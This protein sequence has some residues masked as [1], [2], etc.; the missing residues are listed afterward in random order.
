MN[1]TPFIVAVN[2]SGLPHPIPTQPATGDELLTDMSPQEIAT[3]FWMLQSL[4][5]SYSY[6]VNGLGTYANGYTITCGAQPVERLANYPVFAYESL[7][8]T[9]SMGTFFQLN[10]AQV[11]QGTSTYALN[12][13]FQEGTYPNGEIL[14][15]VN[16]PAGHTVLDTS[17]LVL[18][19][20]TIPLYLSTSYTGLTGSI[21][22][23][24]IGE[25]YW[26]IQGKVQEAASIQNK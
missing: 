4:S 8:E 10:P 2:P 20:R 17:S 19:A 26:Q 23:F 14:L 25:T 5:L 18:F 24:A 1:A 16:I 22:S 21:N 9:T 3:V 7:D 6:T 11:F 13:V 12:L 15:A